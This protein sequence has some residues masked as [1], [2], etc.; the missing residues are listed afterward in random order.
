MER[1]A[2]GPPGVFLVVRE[3]VSRIPPA[4]RIDR[5]YRTQTTPWREPR[6][7]MLSRTVAVGSSF[8]PE[9]VRAG[10]T[11]PGSMINNSAT[12]RLVRAVRV[13]MAK[14]A[15][16]PTSPRGRF[17]R[18]AASPAGRPRGPYTSAEAA[19]WRPRRGREA[20][21]RRRR[22]RRGTH[23]R[24]KGL[25]GNRTPP[26][27]DWAKGFCCNKEVNRRAFQW[28]WLK[29]SEAARP[30]GRSSPPAAPS[31]RTESGSTSARP[32]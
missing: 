2:S 28:T 6:G 31:A 3:D 11:L 12:W 7:V 19:P 21:Q 5:P 1:R 29:V 17:P 15:P 9:Y 24:P 16:R 30:R 4:I 26:H 32:G 25:R 23:W 18:L 27:G 10:E 13:G 14:A 20:S 8:C 22:G